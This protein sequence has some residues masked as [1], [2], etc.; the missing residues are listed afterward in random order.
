[1]SRIWFDQPLETVVNRK[2]MA[3]PECLDWYVQFAH[4][5][6]AATG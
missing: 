5:R 1:M 3:N 4:A 6:Q 2:A